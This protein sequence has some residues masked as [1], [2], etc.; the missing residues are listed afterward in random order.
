MRLYR[1]GGLGSEDQEFGSEDCCPV[2]SSI[3]NKASSTEN[4]LTVCK[5]LLNLII[6]DGK[7]IR[8]HNAKAVCFCGCAT[9]P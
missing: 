3:A 6:V 7:K 8:N 1:I 5:I 4:S 9:I 2:L